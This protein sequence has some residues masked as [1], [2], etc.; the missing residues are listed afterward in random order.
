MMLWKNLRFIDN[1][2]FAWHLIYFIIKG[3]S[4][5]VSMLNEVAIPFF[6][7]TRIYQPSSFL[8]HKRPNRTCS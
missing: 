6:K 8:I 7:M 2:Y 3:Y 1:F 4:E 5:L